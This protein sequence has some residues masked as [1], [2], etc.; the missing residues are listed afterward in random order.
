MGRAVAVVSTSDFEGMPNVFLEG[1][2]RGVPALAL[3]HDP[4][5]TIATHGVGWFAGGDAE[6]FAAQ[7]REAWSTRGDQRELSARCR[8]LAARR[9]G[10]GRWSMPGS[11]RCGA[12][13]PSSSRRRKP[14]SRR[15]SSS[16]ASAGVST[17]PARPAATPA[18][19]AAAATTRAM[20]RAAA[21]PPRARR[22]GR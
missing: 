9:H 2:A 3:R 11:A 16:S 13:P 7:V 17:P 15:R 5:A 14:G 4:D 19:I 1:W 12:Q 22:R 21:A 6:R 18:A 20:P 8:E 10:I